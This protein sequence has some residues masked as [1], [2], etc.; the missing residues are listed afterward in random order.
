M[1]REHLLERVLRALVTPSTTQEPA[2]EDSSLKPSHTPE[3]LPYLKLL[4]ESPCKSPV[5]FYTH[6]LLITSHHK[7][8]R[9]QPFVYRFIQILVND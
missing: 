9:E 5:S 7:L 2:T 6:S 1:Y 4:T 8:T 3:A